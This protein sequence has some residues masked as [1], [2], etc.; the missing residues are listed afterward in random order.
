[1][2]QLKNVRDEALLR[3]LA[4]LNAQGNRTAA[5]LL[6]HLAEVDDRHLYL[7]MGYGSMAAYCVG[8]LHMSEAAARRR[9][10]AAHTARAFPVLFQAI[11]DGRL[12]L[13]AIALLSARFT[14]V[15]VDELIAAATH[16][17]VGEIERL[18]VER[19]PQAEELQFD[20]GVS[21]QVVEPQR[22]DAEGR[23]LKSALPGSPRAAVPA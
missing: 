3:R 20:G 5:E 14:T 10:H 15:N 16:K 8:E 11:A 6:A 23:F 2:Y 12:H 18:L 19:W 1:M 13:T 4:E 7:K 22:S 9:V 21:P 17:T